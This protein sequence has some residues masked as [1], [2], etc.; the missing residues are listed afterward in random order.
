[1]CSSIMVV[2]VNK[3][4]QHCYQEGVGGWATLLY[5]LSLGLFHSFG[6]PARV[7]LGKNA[8]Q[9]QRV[10]QLTAGV[11]FIAAAGLL[12]VAA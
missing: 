2:M 6:C 10:V 5:F 3:V 11:A 8:K 7:N 12:P 9:N 1:M 4:L